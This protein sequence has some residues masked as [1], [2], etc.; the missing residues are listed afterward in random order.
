MSNSTV[1]LGFRQF[2]AL[3]ALAKA[4][5]D[6]VIP[7]T[8]ADVRRYV[9]CSQKWESNI[10]DRLWDCAAKGLCENQTH[11]KNR[12]WHGWV[13]TAEGEARVCRRWERERAKEDR[14]KRKQAAATAE[15]ERVAAERKAQTEA[16]ER[17]RALDRAVATWTLAVAT[18]RAVVSCIAANAAPTPADALGT[19]AGLTYLGETRANKPVFRRGDGALVVRNK[20]GELCEFSGS[21]P[22]LPFDPEKVATLSL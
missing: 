10:A 21:P 8:T 18:E 1:R 2:E 11:P 20:R 22:K 14:R 13:L 4:K 5:G 16:R 3:E 7:A 19:P 17:A 15:A 12:A 6:G 9:G